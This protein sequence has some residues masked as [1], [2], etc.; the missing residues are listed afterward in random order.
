MTKKIKEID[1]MIMGLLQRSN[2]KLLLVLFIACL[3]F[4][5][6]IQWGLPKAVSPETVQPWEFDTIAPIEPL[7]EAYYKFSR[8]GIECPRYP[9]FHYIVLDVVYSPYVFFQYFKGNL[10]NPSATFPYGLKDP[11]KFCRDLTLLSRLV[12]LLMALGIIIVVYKITEELFSH[13]AAFWASIMTTFLVPLTYYAKTSNLDV[14]YIFWSCLAFWQYIRIIKYQQ[15][16]NYISFAICASLSVATK[17]QAYG[18]YAIIPLVIVYSLARHRTKE[19]VK[20]KDVGRA[21]LSKEILLSLITAIAVFA[22]AN[23]LIFGGWSGFVKHITLAEDLMHQ[24]LET[25]PQLFTIANRIS[26]IINSKDVLLQSFGYGSLILCF[27]GIFYVISK[28]NW[29]SLSMLLF[30]LSYYIFCLLAV[31]FLIVPRYLLGPAIILTPFAGTLIVNLL[32]KKGAVRF[33]AALGVIVSLLW[34]VA[35]AVNLNLTLIKDCRYQ[36]EAWIKANIPAGATI[37]TQVALERYLP[38]ISGDYNISIK[39]Q[40]MEQNPVVLTIRGPNLE[41]LTAEAL[42]ERHPQ[43]ILLGSLGVAY[44]PE[45]WQE[46]SLIKY[47]D[48]LLGGKLG[49]RVIA[50]FETPHFVPYRQLAGT[51]PSFILLAKSSEAGHHR[52]TDR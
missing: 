6:G 43:Y 27:S 30:I 32:N 15:L 47:R 11:I 2:R 8:Q 7:T 38:H 14:P 44:D 5:L 33:F 22:I 21:L 37:E 9:L 40:I 16:K 35:L 36:A 25:N 20:L 41:E 49:Y 10:K 51:R 3:N 18:F 52:P 31:G 46:P 26:M 23:N 29:L 24:K 28:R 45:N 13:K 17:D 12:S 34:Q 50:K 39:G 48:A 1:L 19:T 42:K 4:V